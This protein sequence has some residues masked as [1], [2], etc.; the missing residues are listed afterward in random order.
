MDGGGGGGVNGGLWGSRGF[1]ALN[2]TNDTT[3]DRGAGKKDDATVQSLPT[4]SCLTLRGV[5]HL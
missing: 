5:Y 3:A 1:K 4:T 2:G